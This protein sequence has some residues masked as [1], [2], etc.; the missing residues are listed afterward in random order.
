M[1]PTVEAWISNTYCLWLIE[2][3]F[4]EIRWTGKT[5]W[6]QNICK[7]ARYEIQTL[8]CKNWYKSY[9]CVLSLGHSGE[10]KPW[11][12]WVGTGLNIN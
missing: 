11:E 1:L 10:D 3:E 4:P 6:R 5:S 2:I 12:F 8:S 7:Q 9:F